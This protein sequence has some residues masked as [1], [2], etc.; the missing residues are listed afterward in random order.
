MKNMVIPIDIIWINDGKITQINERVEPPAPLTADEDLSLI[1]PENPID[2]VLE[3]R[4]GYT[5]QYN[6]TVGDPVHIPEDL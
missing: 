5:A 1:L 4:A 2:Y 6:I 3:V